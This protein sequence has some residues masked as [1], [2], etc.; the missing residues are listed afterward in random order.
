MRAPPSHV[1]WEKSIFCQKNGKK[2]RFLPRDSWE[3]VGSHVNMP[4][5]YLWYEGMLRT[6][7]RQCGVMREMRN[8]RFKIDFPC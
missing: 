1:T 2:L 6:R 8:F 7:W 4:I 3:F 5:I